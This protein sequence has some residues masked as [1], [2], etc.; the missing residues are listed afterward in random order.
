MGGANTKNAA[1]GFGI[2]CA[3]IL[4]RVP[5][6]PVVMR[7]VQYD[8]FGEPIAQAISEDHPVSRIAMRSGIGLFW[9]AVVVIV[10][11]R[12][13]Y[14]NPAFAETLASVASLADYLKAV[15]GV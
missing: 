3:N 13:A 15:V 4:K 9:A 6:P 7:P 5:T 1:I 12:A 11:A 14:F 2:R 8:S 10:G